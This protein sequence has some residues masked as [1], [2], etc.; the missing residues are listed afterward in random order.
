MLTHTTT[1]QRDNNHKLLESHFKKDFSFK[2]DQTH[3]VELLLLKKVKYEHLD[4]CGELTKS[5]VEYISKI[6]YNLEYT[7]WLSYINTDKH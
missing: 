1:K 7:D 2:Y 3:F 6:V 4:K 5:G